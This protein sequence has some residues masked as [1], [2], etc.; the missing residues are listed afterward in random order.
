VINQLNP[1]D[2]TLH[3]YLAG[4]SDLG[5]AARARMTIKNIMFHYY[6]DE[7]IISAY[8]NT[9]GSFKKLVYKKK[10]SS[11]IPMIK[12]LFLLALPLLKVLV[13]W[14][15]RKKRTYKLAKYTPIIFQHTIADEKF[16]VFQTV[17]MVDF[18]KALH[19]TNIDKLISE[20][21][22]FI[23][24]TYFSVPMH[25]HSGRM[26]STVGNPDEEVSEN[27]SYLGDKIREGAIWNPVLKELVSFLANF[28]QTVCDIDD[29]GKIIA[30]NGSGLPVRI[31]I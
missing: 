5:F 31:V 9:A 16:T 10:V 11:V 4:N 1:N 15:K 26:F 7:K 30:V 6:A 3:R 14:G 27:L 2:F 8:K 22:L 12:N 25:Y 23:A 21:G 28:E 24:H 20:K 29:A 19:K 17:E 18:R 13:F